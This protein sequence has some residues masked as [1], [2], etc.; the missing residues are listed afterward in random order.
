MAAITDLR[1]VG[2]ALLTEIVGP[3]VAFEI[4]T[5]IELDVQGGACDDIGLAV[6]STPHL[7]ESDCDLHS[8]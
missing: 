4:P 8:Y 1:N 6:E 7:K 3:R 5:K 2:E